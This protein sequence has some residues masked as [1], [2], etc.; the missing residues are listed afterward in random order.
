MARRKGWEVCHVAHGQKNPK[1][2]TSFLNSALKRRVADD[3]EEEN[4][5]VEGAADEV[6]EEEVIPSGQHPTRSNSKTSRKKMKKRN[7]LVMRFVFF[8]FESK[9]LIEFK[10]ILSFKGL[11]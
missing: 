2:L 7:S 8:S 4:D 5:N 10:I 1:R 9:Y 11:S 6:E 3:D